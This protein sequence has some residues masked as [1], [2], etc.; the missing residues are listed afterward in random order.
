MD[1]NVLPLSI[2]EQPPAPAPALAPVI[3]YE[4]DLVTVYH[5]KAEHLLPSMRTES[6]DL[7]VVDP[8]YGV[9]YQ[10]RRR[11]EALD[12]IDGDGPDEASRETVRT[13]IQEAVRVVG[14]Q[15]H[16]YVFGPEEV[17]D[18]L[19]VSDVVELIWDKCTMGGGNVRSAWGPQHEPINFTVSKHRHAGKAGKPVLPT[20]L[21][22]GSILSYP[23]PTGLAVRH[24]NEK[25]VG[26]LRELIESSSRQGETI[27]DPTAG[28]L[29]TAVAAVLAGRRA[30]VCESKAEYV[31]EG[32]ERIKKAEK[33]ARAM[34]D[35]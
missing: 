29:S 25:P 17:L 22:K 16:L 3:A 31:E 32:I 35:L 20:R 7:V 4:S 24:P 9:D 15:R 19:K 8:P 34:A 5:G 10:S 21:R 28:I 12:K 27:L 2:P 1:T 18:G 14:Q 6:V 11:A 23:R 33:I 26:L 13:I 30:I